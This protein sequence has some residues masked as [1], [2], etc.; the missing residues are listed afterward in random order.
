MMASA[1]ACQEAL[2]AHRD[3]VTRRR[4]GKSTESVPL[5]PRELSRQRDDDAKNAASKA[6]WRVNEEQMPAFPTECVPHGGA[7][8]PNASAARVA[9]MS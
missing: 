9:A 3:E 2:L 7:Q 1:E 8:I 5:P 6:K 4:L